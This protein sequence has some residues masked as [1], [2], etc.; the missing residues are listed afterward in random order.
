MLEFCPWIWAKEESD[1]GKTRTFISLTTFPNRTRQAK[2]IRHNFK[3]LSFKSH[4]YYIFWVCICSLNYRACKAHASYYIAIY[5]LLACTI[6]FHIIWYK[7]RFSEICCGHTMCVVIFFKALSEICL[8]L[9]IIQWDIIINVHMPS[10]KSP[11]KELEFSW[12]IFEK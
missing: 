7:A 3:L 8:T 10:R 1:D 4:K 6:F 11:A 5:G 9:R 12:H 2:Y